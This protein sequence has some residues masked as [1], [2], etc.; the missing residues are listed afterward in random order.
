M[1][2]KNSLSPSRWKSGWEA[3]CANHRVTW[4]DGTLSGI[5]TPERKVLVTDVRGRTLRVNNFDVAVT[6]ALSNLLFAD[7]FNWWAHVIAGGYKVRKSGGSYEI[8]HRNQWAQYGDKNYFWM[9]QGRK[10]T[11]DEITAVLSTTPSPA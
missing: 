1:D 10:G 4:V 11:P 8:M 5:G 3:E 2:R 9:Q 7:G 6:F